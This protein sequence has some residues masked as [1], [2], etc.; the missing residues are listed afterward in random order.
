MLSFG[1]RLKTASAVG[2]QAS[3]MFRLVE[4]ALYLYSGSYPSHA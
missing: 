2:V 3:L 4:A 1:I